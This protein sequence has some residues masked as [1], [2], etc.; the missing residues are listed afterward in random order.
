MILK[1]LR[2]NLTVGYCLRTVFYWEV[3][4]LVTATLKL[5]MVKITRKKSAY[6]GESVLKAWLQMFEQG[7]YIFRQ[8]LI[9]THGL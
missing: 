5:G 6:N 3:G 7:L 1:V 9:D 2:Q 8:F 4:D